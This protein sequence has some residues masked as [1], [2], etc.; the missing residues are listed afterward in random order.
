M[1]LLIALEKLRQKYMLAMEGITDLGLAIFGA[2]GVGKST[3]ILKLREE[4]K[5]KELCG[6]Y[7]FLWMDVRST[8]GDKR[9]ISAMLTELHEKFSLRDNAQTLLDKLI[10]ALRNKKVKMVILD[11]ILCLLTG[12]NLTQ[13]T[14]NVIKHIQNNS[15]TAIV[16]VGTER[17]IELIEKADKDGEMK[18]RF[19]RLELKKWESA[20]DPNYVQ[21]LALVEA[22]IPLP[23]ASKLSSKQKRT[24]IYS[25]SEGITRRALH[26]I[27]YAAIEAIKSE[28]KC[29]SFEQ[30]QS[31]ESG[32]YLLKELEKA[33]LAPSLAKQTGAE[34]LEQL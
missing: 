5:K 21:F 33:A 16:L 26:L 29:I 12:Q 28:A 15:H 13:E 4:L 11:E 23:D 2:G 24:E 27:K 9:L 30:I 14:L 31:I 17:L 22:R 7:D 18:G 10:D 19:E 1:P 32:A 8:A 34:P 20:D 6:K 25:W 3:V